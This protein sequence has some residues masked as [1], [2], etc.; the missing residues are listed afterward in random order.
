MH[1]SMDDL[2]ILCTKDSFQP[3]SIVTPSSTKGMAFGNILFGGF[4]GAGVDVSTG[5]AYDY[6]SLV[7]VL[8]TP[9]STSM[10][11]TASLQ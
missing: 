1:R 3:A 2:S 11:P 10:S 4:I 9:L 6:P 8:M 5:A 7:P